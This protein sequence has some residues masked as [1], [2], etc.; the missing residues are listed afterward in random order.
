MS[1]PEANVEP[2]WDT[3]LALTLTPAA[4]IHAVFWT[5]DSV[6]TGWD[7]CIDA[8]LI[9]SDIS[10]HDEATGNLCRL[11]K[12]EYV[13]HEASEVTWHDWAVELRIGE[14]FVTGHWRTEDAGSL[15][16]WE[17]CV[18]EAEK[19]FTKACILVGKRIRSGLVVEEPPQ[20]QVPSR[21]HH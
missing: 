16:H 9:V 20:A 19:A 6:H 14:T 10:A 12:Q 5:A 15:A 2:D 3:P 13:E 18:A 8:G 11:V 4:V 21:T 1:D 17:W 7:S